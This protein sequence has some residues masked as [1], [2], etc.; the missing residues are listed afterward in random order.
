MKDKNGKHIFFSNIG[1]RTYK[2]YII[3]KH[4]IGK[5]SNKKDKK[6]KEE[7]EESFLEKE[8]D[9]FDISYQNKKEP[10]KSWKNCSFFLNDEKNEF[11]NKYKYHIKHIQKLKQLKNENY[12]KK[13]KYYQQIYEPNIDY[14]KKRIIIGPKWNLLTGREE[15]PKKD[16]SINNSITTIPNL[17]KLNSSKNKK[18]N[19][20]NIKN[21]YINIKKHNIKNI[22][23][24]NNYSFQNNLYYN[25]LNKKILTAA[26][27]T[28]YLNNINNSKLNNKE[29]KNK[30]IQ[31][32]KSMINLNLDNFKSKIYKLDNIKFNDNSNSIIK[33]I[34]PI[35]ITIKP[36]NV[37]KYKSYT[38]IYKY[39]YIGLNNEE[40]KL[41]SDIKKK[42][43]ITK[44]KHNILLKNKILMKNKINKKEKEYNDGNKS[45]D[46]YNLNWNKKSFNN[47]INKILL[48][49]KIN[50]IMNKIYLKKDKS[51]S[52][53]YKI[54]KLNKFYNFDYDKI[55]IYN[56]NKFDNIAYKSIKSNK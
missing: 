20:F 13:N 28:S 52:F 8:I 34:S 55:D 23:N 29:N 46:I 35:N 47:Y 14:I 41:I 53:S 11:N 32:N 17:R 42:K 51:N 50:N 12:S 49:N 56:Y 15:I 48:K 2:N 45:Y 43:N 26:F 40:L 36:K 18:I 9:I 16:N 30:I 5:K 1:K 31:K 44:L 19:I 24:N 33:Y 7:D 4:Y 3:N 10:L 21:N 39:K 22:E 6:L 38:K 25:K 54:K 37:K 27:N